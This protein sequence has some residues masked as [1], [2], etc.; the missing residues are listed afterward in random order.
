MGRERIQPLASLGGEM[1]DLEFP[2]CGI[3]LGRTRARKFV[4]V[5]VD[6]GYAA[7]GS[8][9]ETEIVFF[10]REFLYRFCTADSAK[11]PF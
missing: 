4:R 11:W 3:L 8:L 5:V 10:K 1:P 7:L 2:R 6:L 9:C